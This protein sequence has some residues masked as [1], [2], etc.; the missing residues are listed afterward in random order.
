MSM[1]WFSSRF[2]RKQRG[3]TEMYAILKEVY[4]E[5][6]QIKFYVNFLLLIHALHI[7]SWPLITTFSK[8]G[9]PLNLNLN[10][11]T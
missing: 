3:Q 8:S 11:K 10:L 2:W 7:H 1:V 4:I 6:F 5:L 9:T